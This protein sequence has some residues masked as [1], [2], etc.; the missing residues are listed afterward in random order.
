MRRRRDALF[1]IIDNWVFLIGLLVR[2]L[3]R[4]YRHDLNQVGRVLGFGFLVGTPDVHLL[5]DS[6]TAF[7][8]L[9]RRKASVKV[10]TYPTIVEMQSAVSAAD[11][12]QI[13]GARAEGER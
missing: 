1:G 13:I 12:D 3:T 5:K 2:G 8:R 4:R 9:C 10:T 11:Q 6:W 7:T